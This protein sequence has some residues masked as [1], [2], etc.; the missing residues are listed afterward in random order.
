MS[1]RAQLQ[2][3]VVFKARCEAKAM[4]FATGELEL[5]KAVDELQDAAVA[6]GLI[7]EIGQ[8]EV[9]K[10][11][12]AALNHEGWKQAANGPQAE[13]P[14]QTPPLSLADWLAR[15]LPAPDLL[16]PWLSTTTR[17]LMF[18]PTGT[19][20][21]TFGIALGMRA[22]AGQGFLHWPSTRKANVLLIDGEMSRRLLLERLTE[23]AK[24]L[25]IAP[26]GMHVLS[27]E[28]IEDFAPLNTL[29]G[30]AQIEWQIARIGK[31]DL[32]LF[33][34]VACLLAGNM[35][36]TEQWAATMPWVKSLTRRSIGQIWMHHSN[37][38]NKSYGD[39]TREWSMDTVVQMEAA[40]RPDT[41]VSFLLGFR[42]ARERTP[43]NRAAFANTK[44]ALVNDRW[45]SEPTERRARGKP[46]SPVG[47]KFF[48]A[49]VNATT[50]SDA[51]KMLN[52]PTAT[53]E[54]WRAECI[55]IGLL[56]KD[57]P[58]SA[59][60][61]FSKHRRELIAANKVACNETIAWTLPN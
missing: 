57:K 36:E 6:L 48:D 33:D 12:V 4:L 43:E 27:H 44:V 9:Q 21:T 1:A 25:G 47:M 35:K 16:L 8:D 2:P 30:Q 10:I 28:D 39:K 40:E 42:K 7:Q 61:L 52:C 26:E 14:L 58:K 17:V 19:G 49:L 34:N 24:R 55:K 32:I 53:I 45:E 41:D 60:A 37:E 51:K 11:I 38:E 54:H 15:D 22:A 3:L 50:T 56:D 20:K 18:G 29:Q 23:E 13:A 5:Y 59:S 31:L 46:P